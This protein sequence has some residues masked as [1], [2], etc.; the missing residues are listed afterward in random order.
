MPRAQKD[1]E[2]FVD[3]VILRERGE[4]LAFSGR[5]P[6]RGALERVAHQVDGR[7]IVGLS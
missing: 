3:G 1:L 7:V 4:A 2:D 6:W 5:T